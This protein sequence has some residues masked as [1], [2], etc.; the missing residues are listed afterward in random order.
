MNEKFEIGGWFG[1][2]WV[3][4]EISKG[5]EDDIIIINGMLY[6]VFLD[7]FREG[8]LGGLMVGVFFIVIDG[9]DDDLFKDD[10]MF[11]YIEVI[12]CF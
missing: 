4:L 9:G 6:F 5:D 10:D 2:I 11:I 1:F 3:R 8:N 12:Y 7:L